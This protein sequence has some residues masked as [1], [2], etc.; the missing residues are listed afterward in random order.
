M[1]TRPKRCC[2][3]HERSPRSVKRAQDRPRRDAG[4]GWRRCTDRRTGAQRIVTDDAGSDCQTVQK[5][6][7]SYDQVKSLKRMCETGLVP[8][9][10]LVCRITYAQCQLEQALS[11]LQE[12]NMRHTKQGMRALEKV[13][14]IVTLSLTGSLSSRT[15]HAIN[16]NHGH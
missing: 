8:V 10:A 3:S 9:P 14:K 2:V 6:R 15:Q 7:R 16:Y 12:N 5:L 13:S 4:P 11:K 1:R